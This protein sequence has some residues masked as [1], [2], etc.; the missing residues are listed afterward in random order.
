M[1][2]ALR[3]K[4]SGLPTSPGVYLF[5]DQKGKVVYVGKAGNLR[6]RVRAYLRP[7]GDGRAQIP[8][9]IEKIADVDFITTGNEKEALLLEDTLV[10]TQR[11]RYNIKLR[12]DKAYLCIRV[13]TK[14]GVSASVEVRF[15]TTASTPAAGMPATPVTCTFTEGRIQPDP[16]GAPAGH[17]PDHT[18]SQ[19]TPNSEAAPSPVRVSSSRAG[20]TGRKLPVASNQP[21]TSATRWVD[22][23]SL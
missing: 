19:N 18:P 11:P 10:K 6:T 5:K 17:S 14:L 21:T 20:G 23:P 12:D 3:R 13:D 4:V 22:P 15:N 2:E 16:N 9:L 8:H 1:S 7:E